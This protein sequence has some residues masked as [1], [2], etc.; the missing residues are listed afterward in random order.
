MSAQELV[1]MGQGS[2]SAHPQVE[3]AEAAG[4]VNS[5][6]STQAQAHSLLS[7]APPKPPRPGAQL[8]PPPKPPRPGAHNY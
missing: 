6:A 3:K 8:Q 7:A 1:A 4:R 5:A 2:G